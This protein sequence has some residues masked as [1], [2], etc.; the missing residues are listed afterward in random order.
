MSTPLLKHLRLIHHEAARLMASGMKQVD[1]GRA[2]GM[3]QSRLSILKSDPAFSGLLAHYRTHDDENFYDA[4]ARIALLGLDA[5]EVIHERIVE[6][7]EIVSTKDLAAVATL[8]LDR[9]GLGPVQKTVA[10]SGSLSPEDIQ[11]LRGVVGSAQEIKRGETSETDTASPASPPVPPKIG[12]AS[13]RER[14]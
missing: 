10:L 8:A 13:C 5:V 9:G 3:S 1:V 4:R 6:E 7:P 14:V 11:E 2:V 12:R